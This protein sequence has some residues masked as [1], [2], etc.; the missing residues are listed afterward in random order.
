MKRLPELVLVLV[1]AIWGGTFLATRA[2]LAGTG[3]F[4]LLF[5]RFGI[6]ALLVGSFIRRKPTGRELY[7]ALMVALVT[8][9]A[10]ATQTIA[11]R[12][13]ESARAAFLTSLYVPLVPL[14]QGPLTGR[15]PTVGA[16]LG[17]ALA[18]AGLVAL[19][20]DGGLTLRFG[21]GEGLLVVGAVAS[22]LQIVLVGRVSGQGDP[23]VLTALQ[24]AGVA[25]LT[26]SGAA[27]EGMRTT[28]T[29]LAIAAGL[30]IVATAGALWAMN[31]A[32]RTVSPSRATLIYALEPVWAAAFGAIAG[33]QFGPWGAVGGGLVVAG[34]LTGEFL[35]VRRAVTA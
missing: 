18:F 25:L 21:L 8:A 30:G 3:P 4:T 2:A 26:L 13:V 28:P 32:Q 12:T 22:A 33:E 27:T 17:A 1:T 23:S 29:G 24:L 10:M 14:L 9:V 20:L 7:G 16:V 15:R 31:W 34:A 5:L 35:P 11:L 6:G 19:S